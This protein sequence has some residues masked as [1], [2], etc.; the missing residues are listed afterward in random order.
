MLVACKAHGMAE[1]ALALDY[2]HDGL[3]IHIAQ[4]MIRM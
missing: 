1:G 4:H 2:T 3:S